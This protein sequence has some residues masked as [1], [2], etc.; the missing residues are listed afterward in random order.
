MANEFPDATITGIDM[1]PVF[2]TT[3]IP[4]NCCFVQHNILDPLPFPDN[5]F[6]FVYQRLLVAG[7]TPDEWTRVLAEL[8]RVTKPGGWIELVEVDGHG[9]NN[10]PYTAKVWSWVEQALMSKGIRSLIGRD[11]G[12]P[13]L[14][15]QAG[16]VNVQQDILKLPTGNHGGKIGNLLKENELSFWSAITPM[17]IHGAGIDKDEYEEALQIAETEVDKYESYHIFYV[18]TAQKRDPQSSTEKP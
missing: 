1:S 8:E 11:P 6:D 17:V 7:L 5:H 16:M 13:Y 4:S 2:P 12:F 9:G 10:G 18:A 14:M 3:I 15:E